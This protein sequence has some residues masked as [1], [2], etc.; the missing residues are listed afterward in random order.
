MRGV[1]RVCTGSSGQLA[2][3]LLW[4][5]LLTRRSVHLCLLMQVTISKVCRPLLPAGFFTSSFS[6]EEEDLRINRE[7]C[8]EGAHP[9]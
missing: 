2:F 6:S 4:A 3:L 8:H 5:T 7:V 9:I 1:A